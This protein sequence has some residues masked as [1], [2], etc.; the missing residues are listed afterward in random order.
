MKL[1][2]AILALLALNCCTVYK[3]M[4]RDFLKPKVELLA[5]SIAVQCDCNS[6]EVHKIFSKLPKAICLEAKDSI[7][8]MIDN[9]R[10][11]SPLAGLA[12]SL[13]KDVIIELAGQYLSEKLSCKIPLDKCLPS[14]MLSKMIDDKICSSI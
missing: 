9:N 7:K 14:G 4:C 10:D 13:T 11:G 12:C 1:C 2:I 3:N 8:D 5:E 6:S